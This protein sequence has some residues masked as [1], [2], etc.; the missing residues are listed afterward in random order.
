M[1]P[2][3]L[4]VLAQHDWENLIG[5]TSN[6]G[7]TCPALTYKHKHAIS[8]PGINLPVQAYYTASCQTSKCRCTVFRDNNGLVN[9]CSASFLDNL[10]EPLPADRQARYICSVQL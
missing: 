4:A 9:L 2:A 7:T 5:N 8:T 1:K 3:V 6:I 10:L